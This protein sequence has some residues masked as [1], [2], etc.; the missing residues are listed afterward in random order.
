MENYHVFFGKYNLY[1]DNDDEP[2]DLGVF[3]FQTE[4]VAYRRTWDDPI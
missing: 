2:M 3:C 4:P 1:S